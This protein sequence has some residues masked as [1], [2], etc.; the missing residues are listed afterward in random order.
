MKA[1]ASKRRPQAQPDSSASACCCCFSVFS[2]ANRKVRIP[3]KSFETPWRSNQKIRSIIVAHV[4]S[5]SAV[6]VAVVDGPCQS[7]IIRVLEGCAMIASQRQMKNLSM[8]SSIVFDCSMLKAAIKKLNWIPSSCTISFSNVI[9][10]FTDLFSSSD[11]PRND[12]LFKD[13][14]HK[15]ETD[16]KVLISSS[17]E[18]SSPLTGL[19]E[20]RS[21]SSIGFAPH[22]QKTS[23]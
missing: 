15:D 12:P 23:S 7:Y 19:S 6:N 16:P 20:N 13:L 18:K 11:T 3:A 21:T 10:N 22:N 8:K 14:T 5:S 9:T 2:L 17:K 4:G 1:A